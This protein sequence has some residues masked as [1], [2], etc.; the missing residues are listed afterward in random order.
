M[1]PGRLTA[2]ASAKPNSGN[3]SR[4]VLPR[5]RFSKKTFMPRVR[6]FGFLNKVL[7]SS[8]EP[9]YTAASLQAAATLNRQNRRYR[10]I[11]FYHNRPKMRLPRTRVTRRRRR[12]AGLV[13]FAR[14]SL[15]KPQS[16]L[17]QA[18]T[19]LPPVN[20]YSRTTVKRVLG[21][22]PTAA[23]L[24]VYKRRTEQHPRFCMRPPTR[25]NIKAI[26][27]VQRRRYARA[28][29]R[30]KR[31]RKQLGLVTKKVLV[32][33]TPKTTVLN[34]KL[35]KTVVQQKVGLGLALRTTTLSRVTRAETYSTEVPHFLSRGG[36][37]TPRK[38]VA[39]KPVLGA[40]G[41]TRRWFVPALSR[42][43]RVHNLGTVK[44]TT[45]RKIQGL[46]QAR[47]VRAMQAAERNLSA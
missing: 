30:F 21:F 25:A 6:A 2:I 46:W 15:Q 43:S 27:R 31:L 33:S 1:T 23:S 18:H 5:A 29:R 39:T 35:D 3:V 24:T 9:R 10:E 7:R 4:V 26:A 37:K 12:K 45:P 44:H 28:K 22:T 13:T 40:I 16:L 17:G 11:R 14:N 36:R 47:S 38:E 41:R 20:A 42:V 8:A 19:L 32:S 34:F